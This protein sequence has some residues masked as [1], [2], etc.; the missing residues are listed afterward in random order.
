MRF[1]RFKNGVGD[2]TRTRDILSHSQ[3]LHQLSYTHHKTV[4]N[5]IAS[6]RTVFKP[7]TAKNGKKRFPVDKKPG[8]M[9]KH[10]S[11]HSGIPFL[12]WDLYSPKKHP[13]LFD[14]P[15]PLCYI[16]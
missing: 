13:R 3:T 12:Q 11:S 6:D 4:S 5:N 2:G 7:K 10:V 1:R 9:F 14:F 8:G 15:R 16:Q